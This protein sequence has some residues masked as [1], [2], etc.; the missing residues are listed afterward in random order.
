MQ[1]QVQPLGI[2]SLVNTAVAALRLGKRIADSAADGIQYSD[3]FA[4]VG[5]FPDIQVI[6]VNAKPALK[7]LKDLTV[8]E[9]ADFSQ[10]VAFSAGLP[11]DQSTFGKIR[12]SLGLCARTYKF[13]KNTFSEG[14]AIVYEFGDIFEIHALQG[15]QAQA[16]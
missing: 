16:A 15:D 6:G 11:A 8:E 2:E 14:K 4:L 7:E 12:A 9:A 10:R 13:V 1:N 5:A 3:A